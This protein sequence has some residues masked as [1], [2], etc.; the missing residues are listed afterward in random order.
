MSI[1]ASD[2]SSKNI[3]QTS[4][5]KYNIYIRAGNSVKLRVKSQDREP[6]LKYRLL[7][8]ERSF[9]HG[10]WW[11]HRTSYTLLKSRQ[12]CSKSVSPD[13]QFCDVIFFYPQTNLLTSKLTWLLYTGCWPSG[14][15]IKFYPCLPEKW[16]I[17]GG[18]AGSRTGCNFQ[19]CTYIFRDYNIL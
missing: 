19:S 3:C 8:E 5:T 11:C 15:H 2:T 10:L 7:G 14:Y 6:Q 17:S 13:F 16:T 18:W 4:H 12:P 1:K 9:S